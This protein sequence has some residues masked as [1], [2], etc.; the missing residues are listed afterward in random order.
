MWKDAV[1]HQHDDAPEDLQG[2]GPRRWAKPLTEVE[3]SKRM[4][5]SCGKDEEAGVRNAAG[6]HRTMYGERK[7]WVF[8]QNV[9]HETIV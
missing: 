5:E 8:V 7:G 9:T 2:V 3:W 1:L 4:E 6:E